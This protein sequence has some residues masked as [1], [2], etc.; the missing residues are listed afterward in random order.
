MNMFSGPTNANEAP[1]PKDPATFNDESDSLISS[2]PGNSPGDHDE[3]N[4]DD[5]HDEYSGNPDS[6]TL[7]EHLN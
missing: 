1:G 3:T 6:Q 2:D 5:V 7:T 4:L